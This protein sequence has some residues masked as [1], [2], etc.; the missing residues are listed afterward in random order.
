MVKFRKY[1]W[2]NCWGAGL[3][4]HNATLTENLCANCHFYREILVVWPTGNGHLVAE[5][6][7]NMHRKA[8]MNFMPDG[9]WPNVVMLVVLGQAYWLMGCKTQI[10]GFVAFF[11]FS[12]MQI[13]T[14]CEINSGRGWGWAS[15]VEE[16]SH[17]W[18][19]TVTLRWGHLRY[20]GWQASSNH[21]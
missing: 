9:Q 14:S 17:A 2:E 7:T 20:C 8:W 3:L 21:V 19:H 15:L 5:R 4:E 18:W 10:T 12:P 16:R 1:L 13:F 11:L 6:S